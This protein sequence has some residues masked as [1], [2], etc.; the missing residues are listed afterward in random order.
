M[1]D[2]IDDF[3]DVAVLDMLGDSITHTTELGVVTSAKA[4]MILD[5]QADEYRTERTN[6]IELLSSVFPSPVQRGDKI[7]H[8]SIDY[9]LDSLINRDDGY[10][11][12]SL[13][14]G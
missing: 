2:F 14:G 5:I 6:E 11:R 12:W 13:K 9:F 7:T 8:N 1:N 10:E 3:P 4:V